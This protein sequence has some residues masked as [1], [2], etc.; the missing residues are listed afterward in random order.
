MRKLSAH[1]ILNPG[2]R[3]L[4]YGVLEVDEEGTILRIRERTGPAE[5]AHLEFFSGILIPGM[6]NVH[7][8]LE[9]SQLKSRIPEGTGLS[10]FTA[11]V[12]RQRNLYPLSTELMRKYLDLMYLDGIQLVG[13]ISNSDASVEAK[14][15]SRPES[16]TFVELFGLDPRQAGQIWSQGK[17]VLNAFRQAGLP[18]TLTA[19]APYSVSDKLW[20]KLGSHP[21]AS[22]VWSIHHMESR[23]EDQLF[24]Q[25]QGAL[26]DRLLQLPLPAGSIPGPDTT[27]SSWLAERLSPRKNILLIHNT[28]A[29]ADQLRPLLEKHP[30]STLF[31]G[32][33]P[34]ANQYIENSLPDEWIS[35]RKEFNLCIGTDSLASNHRLSV[36]EELKTLSRH[37]PEV[38]LEE[39]ISMACLNGARALNR[40]QDYGS[41]EP[42]KKPGVVWIQNLDLKILQITGNSRPKRI[43]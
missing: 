6:V 8:H 25:H 10:R 15:L 27:S 40:E 24:S 36:W 20:E 7:T 3:P 37:Y 1:Y 32:L 12:V 42:G 21:D 18:A 2:H 39:W 17:E 30:Q 26:A 5:E 38:A 28:F 41:F 43:V 13:D 33:C 29:K 16:L 9:L 35:K 11:E 4:P 22:G 34:N 19:H 31:L 14:K 23:E